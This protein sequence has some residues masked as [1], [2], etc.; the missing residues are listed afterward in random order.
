[1][2][3]LFVQCIH[4][5]TVPETRA[6][7]IVTAE[8]KK[9]RKNGEPNVYSVEESESRSMMS[10]E[11]MKHCAS[12]WIRPFHMFVCEPIVLFLSLISGFSDAL[13]FTFLDSLG[14]VYRQWNWDPVR[15]GLAFIP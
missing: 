9:R 13:I 7:C 12:I 3:G 10:R 4:F 2:I 15:I 5:F 6:S 11:G 14:V 8:A 1:M